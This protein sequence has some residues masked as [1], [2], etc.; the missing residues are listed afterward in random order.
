MLF[1]PTKDAGSTMGGG[2][3]ALG[4]F[5]VALGLG[6]RKFR[7]WSRWAAT[8]LSTLGLL[9]FPVGT[10]INAIVLSYLLSKKGATVFSPGYQSVIAATPHVKPKTSTAVWIILGVFLLIIVLGL[11]AIL[12]AAFLKR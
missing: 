2:L 7:P 10:L 1:E 11:I 9:A 6:V 3:L 4:L 8:I 5:Q 12:A